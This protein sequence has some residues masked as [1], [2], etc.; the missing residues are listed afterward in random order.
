MKKEVLI[1]KR[2]LVVGRLQIRDVGYC[3]LNFNE[4]MFLPPKIKLSE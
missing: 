1:C 3:L 4:P 2:S